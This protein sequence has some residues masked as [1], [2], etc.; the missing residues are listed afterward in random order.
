MPKKLRGLV[1]GGPL[2]LTENHGLI[3][4]ASLSASVNQWQPTQPPELWKCMQG[5]LP[6]S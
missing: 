3:R 5:S 1:L 4:T 2:A 6:R